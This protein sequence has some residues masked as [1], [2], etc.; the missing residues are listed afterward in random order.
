MAGSRIK[1]QDRMVMGLEDGTPD[2]KVL[3]C[4]HVSSTRQMEGQGPVWI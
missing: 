3:G 1:L 4:L 2:L